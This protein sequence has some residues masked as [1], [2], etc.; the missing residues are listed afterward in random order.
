METQS[1]WI[2]P[3]TG[4]EL[5]VFFHDGGGAYNWA[6]LARG[7]FWRDRRIRNV[8]LPPEGLCGFEPPHLPQATGFAGGSM[9]LRDPRSG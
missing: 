3:G 9:T 5:R 1:I 2:V 8:R 7:Y 4:N 6:V